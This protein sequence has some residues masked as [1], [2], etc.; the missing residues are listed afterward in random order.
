MAPGSR[1]IYRETDTKGAR[2]K[3]TVKVTP[4]TKRIANG[5]TAR[6][7]R[8]VVT[9][10]GEPVEVP[11]GFFKRDV[12]MTRGAGLVQAWALTRRRRC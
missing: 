3:V 2:Q 7:V 10:G 8:D 5:V 12:L 9:E 1:W 6:V 11:F 4:K